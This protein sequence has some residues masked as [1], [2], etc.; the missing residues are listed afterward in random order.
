MGNKHKL[1]ENWRTLLL[2][3]AWGHGGVQ[4]TDLDS[5]SNNGIKAAV[6]MDIDGCRDQRDMMYMNYYSNQV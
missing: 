6:N 1:L 2:Q 4:A 3:S 5:T